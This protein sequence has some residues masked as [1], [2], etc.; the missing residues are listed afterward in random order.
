[1]GQKDKLSIQET[2]RLDLSNPMWNDRRLTDLL[3]SNKAI[4][5]DQALT[6]TQS[7]R[8]QIA[9]MK[10]QTLTIPVFEKFIEAK[11]RKLGLTDAA[12]IRLDESIFIQP[13]IQL[14]DNARR[15]LERRYLKK[16]SDGNVTETPE[17]LF[18][19]VAR[20]AAR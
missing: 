5:P 12:P 16:D 3:I 17:E 8:K 20:H 14:S 1:M 11:L 19:R 9:E 15:V 13:K 7:I 4:A 10:Q 6:I 18:R 2:S